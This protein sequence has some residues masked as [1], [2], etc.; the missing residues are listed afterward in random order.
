MNNAA[1]A[2][3]RYKTISSP[4][5]GKLTKNTVLMLILFIWLW[6]T[7]FSVLPFLGIWGRFAPEGFL[8][9][10]SFDYMSDDQGT[11]IFVAVIFVYSYVI[12]LVFLIFFY[13]KIIGHVHEHEAQLR[14]QA[15]KMNVASLRSNKEANETS[16]EVRIAKVALTLGALFLTAWTPYA[17]VALTACFGNR[18]TLTPL[19]SMVPACCCKGVACINPWIY[20][21]NHPRYRLELQKRMPWFCIHEPVPG[22][23]DNA[24]ANSAA[25]DKTAAEST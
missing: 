13:S 9:T 8:T 16:A 7:P 18:S 4:L 3:D 19:M 21:I 22:D 12:P 17:F 14:A 2:Y 1:I 11:K 15:K 24:S 10:C 25:S 6:A 5:D 20:A 23:G